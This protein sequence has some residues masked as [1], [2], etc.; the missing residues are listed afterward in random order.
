MGSGGWGG[1]GGRLVSMMDFAW[2]RRQ[3]FTST[4]VLRLRQLCVS[5]ALA[6]LLPQPE[7]WPGCAALHT[8]SAR[9][10]TEASCSTA[11]ATSPAARAVHSVAVPMRRHPAV[12]QLLMRPPCLGSRS[13]A[14]RTG[15]ASHPHHHPHALRHPP[16]TASLASS[17]STSPSPRSSRALRMLRSTVPTNSMRSTRRERVPRREPSD[18]AR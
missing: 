4:R 8:R 7:C 1:Q 15:G 6:C 18:H 9:R 3:L 13:S 10:R 16:W 11:L 5:P 14:S 12:Q 17:G 2:R